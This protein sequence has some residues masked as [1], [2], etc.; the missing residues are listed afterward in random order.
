MR[1]ALFQLL[2]NLEG[3]HIHFTLARHRSDTVLV[4]FTL[5]GERVEVDVFEDGHMEVSRFI[6]DE[7]IEGGEEL[8]AKL[9]A[10]E[11]ST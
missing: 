9:I 10:K 7:G 5:V 6:G 4:T 1:H 2:S 8:V 11:S 3:E